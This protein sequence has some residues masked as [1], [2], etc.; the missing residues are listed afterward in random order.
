MDTVTQ[1]Q[2]LDEAVCISHN[3]NTLGRYE[4]NYLAIREI[5]R[6]T[7]LFSLD[8]A[9]SLGEGKLWIQFCL[10]IDH[11]SHPAGAVSLVNIYTNPFEIK[12]ALTN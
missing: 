1:V 11:V 7:G 12:T 5:A 9:T 8:M 3:A 6:Q 10:K 2:I 4:S